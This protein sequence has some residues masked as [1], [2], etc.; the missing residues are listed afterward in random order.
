MRGVTTSWLSKAR[1]IFL[2]LAM[3]AV[4][5][6]TFVVTP[7]VHAEEAIASAAHDHDGDPHRGPHHHGLK[8]DCALCH[9]LAGAGL[10][11]PTGPGLVSLDRAAILAP[12]IAAERARLARAPTLAYRSRAPPV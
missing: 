11:A 2:A 7:H 4:G 6:Q 8:I 1:A 12:Y 9:S 10:A 5:V 3:L